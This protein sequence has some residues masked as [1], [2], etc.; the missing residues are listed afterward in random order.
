MDVIT[1]M[2]Q[3][4]IE[5]K[6]ILEKSEEEMLSVND[7]TQLDAKATKLKLAHEAYKT[8]KP[9]NGESGPDF[10]P[11]KC[12]F[13][14][15]L[16][17]YEILKF[18]NKIVTRFYICRR[19]ISFLQEN[20]QQIPTSQVS[21]IASIISKTKNI[22]AGLLK[23]DD[24]V[25]VRNRFWTQNQIEC[26]T[27]EQNVIPLDELSI[28]KVIG[29]GSYGKV[30]K[31]TYN[32][33]VV[34][35]KSVTILSQ[36]HKAFLERE[37]FILSKMNHENV[38]R[39]IGISRQKDTI[40]L[41]TELVLYGELAAAVA[42]DHIPRDNWHIKLKMAHQGGLSIN[43]LHEKKIIHNDIK[44]ENMLI[45]EDWNIK[46]CDFGFA[47]ELEGEFFNDKRLCGTPYFAAPEKLLLKNYTF[48]ADVYAYGICMIEIITFGKVSL[49][50]HISNNYAFDLKKLQAKFP[51]DCPKEF[52]KI[53]IEAI[54]Y[55]PEDRPSMQQVC[56]VLEKCLSKVQKQYKLTPV[57]EI[58]CIDIDLA[59]K[60]KE[61]SG[62]KVDPKLEIK[63]EEISNNVGSQSPIVQRNEVKSSSAIETSSEGTRIFSIDKRTSVLVDTDIFKNEKNPHN[64]ESTKRVYSGVEKKTYIRLGATVI[65]GHIAPKTTI[66]IQI[67]IS[68]KTIKTIEQIDLK[69]FDSENKKIDQVANICPTKV[70]VVGWDSFPIYYKI[71]D[72]VVGKEYNIVLIAQT[73]NRFDKK[74]DSSLQVPIP[75]TTVDFTS[76]FKYNPHH[77]IGAPYEL[78]RIR[79]TT[80]YP[81]I[82]NDMADYFRKN[83]HLLLPSFEY[84]KE[85]FEQSGDEEEIS[86][87]KYNYNSGSTFD[88]QKLIK[89]PFSLCKVFYDFLKFLPEPVITSKH[90]QVILPFA[91]LKT[92]GERLESLKS[93]F[94]KLPSP[95][96]SFLLG[97]L[98]FFLQI[99]K[100]GKKLSSKCQDNN[101]SQVLSFFFDNDSI[102]RPPKNIP[103]TLD[104]RKKISILIHDM[105][106]GCRYFD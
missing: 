58:V 86:L 104:A 48:K 38:L 76:E 56:S 3:H 11:K 81:R 90:F 23:P 45:S 72:I 7:W 1:E 80:D 98:S 44:T 13:P 27:E 35:V 66:T 60:R 10:E 6:E 84:S 89:N 42:E 32:E 33:E 15:N 8:I 83:F 17:T 29:E 36:A 102:L 65:S 55:D 97:L 94:T 79:E 51:S 68:N 103:Y 62:V 57:P 92:Q 22:L 4:M 39:F 30:Y 18:Q 75:F 74:T 77:I 19:K 12:S 71:P 82:F 93:A 26:S 31:A 87:L 9:I 34:A 105:I 96:R 64:S 2:L 5:C 85:T 49:E 24:R 88:V 78:V 28:L 25:L 106:I 100:L 67:N 61:L 99:D 95:N 43:Y 20:Y 53:A 63:S 16:A 54:S 91:D 59:K 52:A 37:L 50:R 101:L 46:L 73:K 14:V 41:I 47:R 40:Y 69:L 21:K 70:P